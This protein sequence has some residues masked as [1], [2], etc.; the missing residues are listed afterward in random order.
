MATSLSL[1]IH[2]SFSVKI[3][4]LDL[5]HTGFA[6]SRV[7]AVELVSMTY[8]RPHSFQR[9]AKDPRTLLPKS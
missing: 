7:L 4:S 6:N 9:K 1:H 8:Q 2:D 3:L 5:G